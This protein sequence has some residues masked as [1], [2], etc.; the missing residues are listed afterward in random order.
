MRSSIFQSVVTPLVLGK[1]FPEILKGVNPQEIGVVQQTLDIF[2][3]GMNRISLILPLISLHGFKKPAV[4]LFFFKTK[5]L[6]RTLLK[7]SRT[8]SLLDHS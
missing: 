7:V 5:L 8:I 3:D 4:M 2:H 1:D 6:H